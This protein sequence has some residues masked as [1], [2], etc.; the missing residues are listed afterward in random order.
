MV[1]TRT[2]LHAEQIRENDYGKILSLISRVN[3]H[4]T[5]NA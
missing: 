5:N 3:V 4:K 2:E 1:G